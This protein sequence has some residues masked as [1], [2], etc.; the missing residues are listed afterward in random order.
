[1]DSMTNEPD[2]RL[3]IPLSL[4]IWWFCQILVRKQLESICVWT[5]GARQPCVAGAAGLQ[6]E[7]LEM[8]LELA[9]LRIA[10]AGLPCLAAAI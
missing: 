3:I 4:R 6:V 5:C 1:M 2:L 9:L 10:P 8:R 7:F